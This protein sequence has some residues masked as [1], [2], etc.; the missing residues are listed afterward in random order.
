M[1]LIDVPN[2]DDA[3]IQPIPRICA[4]LFLFEDKTGKHGTCR[5][6]GKR[7]DSINSIIRGCVVVLVDGDQ[8]ACSGVPQTY[9]FVLGRDIAPVR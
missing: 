5:R 3:L 1:T 4:A 9:I 7:S 6:P 2:T 8:M